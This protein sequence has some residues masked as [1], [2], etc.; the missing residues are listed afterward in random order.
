MAWPAT[1][2]ADYA[3]ALVTVVD[4]VADRRNIGSLALYIFLAAAGLLL[5]ARWR[6]TAR[7]AC[8]GGG[9]GNG[10]DNGT[11]TQVETGL[12]A[13]GLSVLV[14]PFVPCTNLLSPV[15]FQI[16]ERVLYLPSAGGCVLA[17]LVLRAA[18]ARCGYYGTGATLT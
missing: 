12:L 15:G 14:V 9:G 17:V 6:A 16:A 4:S 18:L 7:T 5:L 10:N 11:D 3:N 13:L 1:L 2:R 8:G